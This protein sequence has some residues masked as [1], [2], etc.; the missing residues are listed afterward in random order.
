[1]IEDAVENIRDHLEDIREHP[2]PDCLFKIVYLA[3]HVI[4]LLKENLHLHPYK[5]TTVQELLPNYPETA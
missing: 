5:V 4:K 2:L 1:V 3:V